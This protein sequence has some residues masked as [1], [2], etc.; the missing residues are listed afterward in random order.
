MK[1]EDFYNLHINQTLFFDGKVCEID[2]LGFSENKPI[3]GFKN[4][5]DLR[6]WDYICEKVSSER[7]KEPL[8]IECEVE[9]KQSLPDPTFVYP[10]PIDLLESFCFKGLRGKRGTLIFKEHAK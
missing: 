7:P 3:V 9:W 4:S 10:Q 5:D 2:T 8:V 6:I 1:H